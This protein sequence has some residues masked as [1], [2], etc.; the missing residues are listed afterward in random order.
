MKSL[1][2][3]TWKLT[4]VTALIGS[5]AFVGHAQQAAPATRTGPVLEQRH[6]RYALERDDVILL[7]FPLSPKIEKQYK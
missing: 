5:T 6:P 4:V 2:S 7:T 3:L 1:T